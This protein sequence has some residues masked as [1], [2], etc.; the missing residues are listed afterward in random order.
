MSSSAR[1]DFVGGNKMVLCLVGWRVSQPGRESMGRGTDCHV[2]LRPPH[3]DK[4]RRADTEVR[5]YGVFCGL[6]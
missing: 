5:P 6:V 4:E 3:N 1:A 2:G